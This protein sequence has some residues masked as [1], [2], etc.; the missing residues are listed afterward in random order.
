MA[1]SQ[2]SY[3]NPGYV[4][5]FGVGADHLDKTMDGYIERHNNM[6]IQ[7]AR[8]YRIAES[9]AGT[10]K[11]TTIGNALPQPRKNEDTDALPWLTPPPGF[12]KEFEMVML[13]AGIRVTRRM[14][15]RQ[16]TGK[17]DFLMSG[18]LDAARLQMEFAF[19]NPFNNAQAGTLTGA[20]GRDLVDTAHPFESKEITDTWSNVETGGALSYDSF[21]TA[22]TNMRKRTNERNN[23]MPIFPKLLIVSPDNEKM[24]RE[25]KRSDNAPNTALRVK[26]V[27]MDD[28]WDIFV[29]DFLTSTTAWYLWGNIPTERLG[30]VHIVEVAPNVAPWPI[31][32]TDVPWAQRLRMSYATGSTVEKNIQGNAGA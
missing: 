20:D 10:Y 31:T 26:N 29:W 22:R 25:I 18:L 19:A 1:L 9:R 3:G 6:P 27:W 14:Q 24:A 21:S 16:L 30:M 5:R 4:S 28:D 2:E 23:P 8:F 17:V 32:N 7:G 12:R 15:E 13:R 11:E